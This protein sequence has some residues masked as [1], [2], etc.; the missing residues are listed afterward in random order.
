MYQ[1][2]CLAAAFQTSPEGEGLMVNH[3]WCSTNGRSILISVDHDN[4]WYDRYGGTNT[5]EPGGDTGVATLADRN[6]GPMDQQSMIGFDKV[7]DTSESSTLEDMVIQKDW[8]YTQNYPNSIRIC[9]TR[10]ARFFFSLP[11]IFFGWSLV[12]RGRP[13][14]Q[15]AGPAAAPDQSADLNQFWVSRFT[16]CSKTSVSPL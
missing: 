8:T 14:D 3:A 4:G 5:R 12:R 13:A 10:S 11:R 9:F 16:I 2:D 1:L 15:P 7:L 6:L